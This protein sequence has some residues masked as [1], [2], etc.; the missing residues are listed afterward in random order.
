MLRAQTRAV[1]ML[2]SSVCCTSVQALY[3]TL[4]PAAGA[5]AG[6]S[7]CSHAVVCNSKY[8]PNTLQPAA[9]AC[10]SL[11]PQAVLKVLSLQI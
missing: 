9:A 7:P 2:E 3:D 5:A 6:R 4:R 1:Y 8:T 11:G 10:R